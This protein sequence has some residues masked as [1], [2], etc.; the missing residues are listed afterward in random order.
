MGVDKIKNKILEDADIQVKKILEEAEKEK[1]EILKKAEEEAN[2]RY[3][4]IIKRGEKEAEMVYNR[5][6]A[7]AKLEAKKK[8][9]K[10]KEKIIEKAIQKIKE[11]LFKL[12]EKPEYRDKLYKLT[13]EAIELLGEEDSYIAK[14]NKR[15]INLLKEIQNELKYD[16]GKNITLKV[17]TV[18]II[19]GIILQTIDKTKEVDNSLEAIFERKLPEIRIKLSEKLF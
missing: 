17:E 18:D 2:K 13:V 9:L 4:E 5:I 19:G 7:E 14:I 1:E 3:E 16:F 8:L 11:D 15:D 10:A 12:P 6:I